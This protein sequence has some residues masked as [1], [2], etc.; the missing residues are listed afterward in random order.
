MF[1]VSAG[2]WSCSAVS[3]ADFHQAECLLALQMGQQ[4]GCMAE[5]SVHLHQIIPLLSFAI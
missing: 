5:E 4:N 3:L 2:L 1:L